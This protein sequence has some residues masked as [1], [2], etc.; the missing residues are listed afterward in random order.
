METSKDLGQ[1]DDLILCG[2]Y[3]Y[4]DLRRRRYSMVRLH[5]LVGST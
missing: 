5:D 4:A 3:I 1:R 2:V